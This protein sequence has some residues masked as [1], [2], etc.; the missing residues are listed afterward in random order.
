MGLLIAIS[1]ATASGK[2]T[3][4]VG[5]CNLL[6]SR[7]QVL[8]NQDHYFR[9]FQEIP[10]DSR[11]E[12]LTSN[13]P[14]AVLW[15]SLVYHLQTLKSGGTVTVPVVGTRARLRGDEPKNLGPSELVIIEGHLLFNDDRILG[16]ADLLVFMDANP[17]ERAVRRLLRDTKSGLTS[18]ESAGRWFRKDVIPNIKTYSEALR[19]LADVIVPFDRDNEVAAKAVADWA[20]QKLDS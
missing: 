18:L 19:D 17:H 6:Q 12:A 2:S 10:E 14:R 8:L 16:L 3:F 7:S 11:E 13:H 1:G 9:D 15:N 20:K 5:L 4:A